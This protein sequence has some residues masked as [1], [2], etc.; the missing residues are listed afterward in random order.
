[1]GK[2]F[3]HILFFFSQHVYLIHLAALNGCV[4]SI[5]ACWASLHIR[6][7]SLG[8]CCRSQVFRWTGAASWLLRVLRGL[9]CSTWQRWGGLADWWQ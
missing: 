4:V 9:L 5:H 3:V 6:V 7:V 8:S 1:V 2:A